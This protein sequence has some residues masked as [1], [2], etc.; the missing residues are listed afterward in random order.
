M[1]LSTHQLVEGKQKDT[2]MVKLLDL[3][4]GTVRDIS[5]RKEYSLDSVRVEQSFQ[6]YYL[7]M[8]NMILSGTARVLPR[9]ITKTELFFYEFCL[10][11]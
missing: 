4:P 8:Q 3:A 2:L 7:D 9:W 11:D 10:S 5:N 6:C 1:L